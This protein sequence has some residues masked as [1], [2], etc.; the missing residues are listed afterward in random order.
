ML[1]GMTGK[2]AAFLLAMAE[3]KVTKF[4]NIKDDDNDVLVEKAKNPDIEVCSSIGIDTKELENWRNRDVI[5]NERYVEYTGYINDDI[6][7]VLMAGVEKNDT[8]SIIAHLAINNTRGM[9]GT[10]ESC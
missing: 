9:F 3:I 1:S 10:G 4:I 2:K 8:N 7:G 6:S 5:F